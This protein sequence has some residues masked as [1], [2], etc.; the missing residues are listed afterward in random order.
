MERGV[1]GNTTKDAF[2]FCSMYSD[3]AALELLPNSLGPKKFIKPEELNT[4]FEINDI[5]ILSLTRKSIP[6][7]TFEKAGKTKAFDTLPLRSPI[8]R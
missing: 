4:L 2:G 5:I 6:A 3:V 7:F 8:Y 1:I